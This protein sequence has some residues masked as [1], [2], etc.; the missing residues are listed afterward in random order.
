MVASEAVWAQTLE[1]AMGVSN[2][3]LSDDAVKASMTKLFKE[4]LADQSLHAQ[5][6]PLLLSHFRHMLRA[7]TPS[8]RPSS[9]R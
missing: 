1:L 6:A 2:T 7:G 5:V 3:V 4:T 9:T 8:G